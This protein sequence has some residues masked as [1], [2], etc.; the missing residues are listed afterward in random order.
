[1]EDYTKIANTGNGIVELLKEALVPELLNS[2]DQ[3]GLCSPED[4][5]DFAVGVWLYDLREDADIQMHDMVNMGK[6]SQR[7]PSVYLALRYMIT[8]YLQSDLKYRAVQEHQI[9]G[10]IIQ[11]LR[12]R[13][14]LDAETLKP[15]QDASGM[16]IRIQMQNLS[17][18]EKMRIWTFPNTPYKASLFYTAG[19]VEI[20]STRKKEVRRVRDIQYHF[21]DQE[22]SRNIR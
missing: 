11:V 5:G 2:P 18:E 22:N 7:Y 1:M 14:V 15:A 13:A 21:T 16:N 20:K 6:D 9:M 19:P 3:V 10:R 17:I 4:H 12:D 8:L